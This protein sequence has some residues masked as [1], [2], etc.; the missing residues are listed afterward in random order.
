MG[1]ATAVGIDH[2]QAIVNEGFHKVAPEHDLMSDL[3]PGGLHLVW[4]DTVV[5]AAGLCR[6][7]RYYSSLDV[8]LGT[9]ARRSRFS[10]SMGTG[11]EHD[12]LHK[13]AAGRGVSRASFIP[14]QFL[15]HARAQS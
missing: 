15:D 13:A 14:D 11:A 1:I 2:K 8:A 7:W 6:N 5:M 4:K 9:G 12:G 10:E 3:K